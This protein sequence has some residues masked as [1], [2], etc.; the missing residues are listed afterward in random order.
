MPYIKK[1]DRVR[2]E[3]ACSTVAKNATSAG[4]LNFALTSIIH[5]YLKIKGIKYANI[6]EVIGMLECCKME[7]YRKVAGPYEEIKIYENGDV[8]IILPKDLGGKAY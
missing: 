3:N 2:F 7:L 4:D 5:Q 8:D 6:N 1:E